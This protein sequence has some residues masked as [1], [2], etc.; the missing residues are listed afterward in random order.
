V[1]HN[2]NNLLQIIMSS[3]QS[4]LRSVIDS[5]ESRARECLRHVLET[6]K[7][8]GETVKRLQEFARVR[9]QGPMDEGEVFDISSTVQQAVEMSRLWLGSGPAPEDVTIEIKTS[10]APGC[11]VKGRENEIFE[12]AL[13]LVKN[14]AEA[15][16]RGGLIKVKTYWSNDDCFLE[17]SDNG[18]GIAE[19]FIPKIFDPFW[20]TKGIRGT[21]MGLASSYGIVYRHHG[22]IHVDSKPGEGSVFTVKLPRALEEVSKPQAMQTPDIGK[23]LTLLV[24]EDVPDILA[25]IGEGLDEAGRRPLLASSGERGLEIF[26]TEAVDAVICD[27]GMEGLTGWDVG[28]EIMRI[29]KELNRPKTPFILL[30]GWAAQ[31]K[32]KE[33][34]KSAGVDRVLE[35]PVLMDKLLEV[36]NDLVYGSDKSKP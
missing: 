12:V 35:K 25:L 9:R 15:L 32:G 27:L 10:L 33:P 34:L 8:G 21:G 17:V 13:N 2:F 31:I 14:S 20:T 16:T 6:S 29:N 4:G 26:K 11:L 22:S 28:R 7:H 36:I 24:I 18:V 5:N 1:A 23:R 30:T 19:A 3:A